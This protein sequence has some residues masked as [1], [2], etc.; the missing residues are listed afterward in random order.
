MGDRRCENCFFYDNGLCRV[1]PP[2]I[3][4]ERHTI[5]GV[6]YELGWSKVRPKDWCGKHQYND[7]WYKKGELH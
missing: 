2:M 4:G 5:E 6:E 1:D 3:I 7:N